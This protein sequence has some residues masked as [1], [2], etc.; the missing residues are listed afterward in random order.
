MCF[1]FLS[2]LCGLCFGA[3][4]R[5]EFDARW[6]EEGFPVRVLY[7]KD[8]EKYSASFDVSHLT[9]G[10]DYN[11][12]RWPRPENRVLL[13]QNLDE[14]LKDQFL[15]GYGLKDGCRM[16]FLKSPTFQ[17]SDVNL[18][19]CEQYT[20]YSQVLNDF[21]LN[22]AFPAFL[23][24]NPAGRLTFQPDCEPL[25]PNIL[26]SVF[27]RLRPYL[28]APF[29]DNLLEGEMASS[30]KKARVF[31]S[32]KGVGTLI[33]RLEWNF[34]SEE[35]CVPVESLLATKLCYG[36]M[37]QR[38]PWTPERYKNCVNCKSWWKGGIELQPNYCNPDNK[39]ECYS[40][41]K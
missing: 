14:A 23:D 33:G 12:S 30:S 28:W 8:G 1:L 41:K 5:E 36:K 25:T 20:F 4:D 40:D 13:V 27:G 24:E 34:L 22:D 15:L 31:F 2:V 29:D 38:S 21:L 35:R 26:K 9:F 18:E 39:P 3:S 6:F 32:F 7:L 16:P 10:V 19:D 17:L 11:F 37:A